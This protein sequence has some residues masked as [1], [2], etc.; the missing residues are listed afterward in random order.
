MEYQPKSIIFDEQGRKALVNGITILSKAVKSTLGPSG[1]TVIIESPY[2]TSGMTVTKDG[3]TVAKSIELVDPVENIAVRIMKQA[4]ERTAVEAG[5]G[6][7]TS[8]ILTEAIIKAGIEHITKDVNA[9]DV[10]RWIH[11][12][13]DQIVVKLKSLSTPVD[14]GLLESITTVS[15]NNNPVIGKII[16]DVYAEIG[17][18]GVVMVERS[19]DW[20][21]KSLVIDGMRVQS[22]MLS[23][24]F[25]NNAKKDE[26]I[27]ENAYVL[28]CQSEIS[29]FHQ[30]ER[31]LKFVVDDRV[32]LIIIA[33]CTPQFVNTIGANVVKNGLKFCV[34][35]PPSNGYRQDE[36]MGDIAAAVGATLF[37]E[38]TGDDLSLIDASD[39]GFV[40]KA[41]IGKSESV[42]TLSYHDDDRLSRVQKRIGQLKEIEE[43]DK[44]VLE[45]I[46]TL[47]GGIGVVYVGGSTDIEHKELY[48]R[49]E[50]AVLAARSALQE[51]ILPGGG[52]ALFDM[53]HADYEGDGSAE[54]TCACAI[55][56]QALQAP[57]M[58]IYENAGMSYEKYNT[59][60][61]RKGCGWDT[62]SKIYGD[63]VDMGII[64]PMKVTRCALENA[65]SVA[66]TILTT[67]AIVTMAR[68]YEQK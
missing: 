16:A 9:H 37:S 3:V 62:R 11:K 21:T 8:I 68:T 28:V 22:G 42:F 30:I 38:K 55:L 45:R 52:V 39:L 29:S 7:T 35:A 44:F 17:P 33:P 61:P 10:I 41:V 34:M 26:C 59:K 36:L 24:V 40:E 46:A 19:D 1:H 50:D 48:D 47:S 60:P 12:L 43:K 58:Q 53:A 18:D 66:V 2:H 20:Q 67:N 5:D 31:V 57:L 51:G 6:T 4:A 25:I 65:V 27:L 15:S 56:S 49:V 32:P 54:A 64:D 23:N 13:T 63:M 14:R